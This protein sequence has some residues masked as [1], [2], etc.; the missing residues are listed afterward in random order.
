MIGARCFSEVSMG[1]PWDMA[2]VA[3][4]RELP[5]RKMMGPVGAFP[6]PIAPRFR[7]DPH[8]EQCGYHV[9]G[10]TVPT[11][12]AA[13][14]VPRYCGPAGAEEPPGQIEITITSLDNVDEVRKALAK[15]FADERIF[16]A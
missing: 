2:R 10:C 3:S 13:R 1:K 5:K 15:A 6:D 9:C 8:C 16:I 12:I 4:L 11:P 7:S 14:T